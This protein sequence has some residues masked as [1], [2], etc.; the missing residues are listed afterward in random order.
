MALL[1]LDVVEELLY[2]V[3]PRGVLG[4]EQHVCLE[5]SRCLV[6]GG[7]LVDS[8]VVHQDDNV[9]ALR[10]GVHTQLVQHTV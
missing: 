7:H 6:N 1:S 10:A 3:K 9:L 2:G 5:L 8:S 4:V